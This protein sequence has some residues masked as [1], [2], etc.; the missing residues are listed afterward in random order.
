[1]DTITENAEIKYYFNVGVLVSFLY[2]QDMSKSHTIPVN[3]TL[4]LDNCDVFNL[5]NMT[6]AKKRALILIGEMFTD[7]EMED[8][9]RNAEITVPAIMSVSF[10]GSSDYKSFVGSVGNK[11]EEEETNTITE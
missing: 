1:M 11:E 8:W 10:L 9:I 2:P 5:D 4:A 7:T 6:R 3:V